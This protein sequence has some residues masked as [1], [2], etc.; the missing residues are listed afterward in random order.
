MAQVED[1]MYI[2]E[3]KPLPERERPRTLYSCSS[4]AA[5][6]AEVDEA[7]SDDLLIR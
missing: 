4:K 6:F 1:V 2:L 5:A 7:I 3:K